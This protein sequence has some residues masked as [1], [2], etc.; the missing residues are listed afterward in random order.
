MKS[1]D[2]HAKYKTAL[3]EI[4]ARGRPSW[5]NKLCRIVEAYKKRCEDLEKEV[6]LLR[7]GAKK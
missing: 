7:K 4:E 3:E 6:E 5:C 2:L 1:T